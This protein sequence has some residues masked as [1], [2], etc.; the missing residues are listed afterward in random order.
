MSSWD[1]EK[2]LRKVST[3]VRKMDWRK[4]LERQ[5]KKKRDEEQHREYHKRKNNMGKTA[6]Q[7][8]KEK[9]RTNHR[10]Y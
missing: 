4:A 7:S 10:T 8:I 6:A 9:E 2:C 1:P 3:I 5:N